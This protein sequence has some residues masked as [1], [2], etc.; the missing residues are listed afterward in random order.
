MLTWPSV[1]GLGVGYAPPT[2]GGALEGEVEWKG[3]GYFKQMLQSVIK[4][5][6]VTFQ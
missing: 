4:P 5:L 6:M 3:S 2:E 1:S